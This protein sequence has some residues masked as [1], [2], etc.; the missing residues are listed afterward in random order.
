MELQT[1]TTTPLPDWLLPLADLQ[2]DQQLPPPELPPQTKQHQKTARELLELQYDNL[3]MRTLEEV[4]SGQT[5][6][7]I[8][9]ND[10]RSFEQGA[11]LRWINKDS[12]RSRLFEEAKMLRTECWAGGLDSD[13]DVTRSKLRID[14]RFRLMESDNRPVYGKNTT[15]NV[16]GTISILGALEQAKNRVINMGVAQEVTQLITDERDSTGEDNE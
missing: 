15:V 5:L 1:D 7:Q 2:H 16:G 14:T 8:L 13:E 10:L 3:F 4:A 9:Q 11:F 6:R 12:E